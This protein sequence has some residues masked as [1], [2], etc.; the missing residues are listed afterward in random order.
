MYKYNWKIGYMLFEIYT[1]NSK[2]KNPFNNALKIENKELSQ[3]NIKIYLINN[4]YEVKRLVSFCD[5]NWKLIIPKEI[6]YFYKSINDNLIYKI[7]YSN[8]VNKYYQNDNE[9]IAYFPYPSDNFLLHYSYSS[10]I[11]KLYGN[12]MNLYRVLIDFLTINNKYLPLHS[13]CVKNENEVICLL[14]DS[15]CGKTSFTI[16]LL[17]KGFKFI[18]DD[19]LF[20]TDKEILQVNKIIGICKKFPN[21]DL[22]EKLLENYNQDKVYLDVSKIG[23]ISKFNS[24]RFSSNPLFIFLAKNNSWKGLKYMKEPFPSISHHSFWCLHYFV[25]ENQEK[26]IENRVEESFLF[27][28]DKLKNI[29]TISIDF[30]NFENYIEDFI[31]KIG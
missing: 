28:D 10:N 29:K 18:S 5:K 16:K 12:E 11:I 17:E 25:K 20:A 24:Y 21:N 19:S 3:T 30:N 22:I 7:D 23:K 31:K 14:G 1:Y 26:W 2:L 6:Q 8:H 4:I 13:S 9:I 15:G 27:W